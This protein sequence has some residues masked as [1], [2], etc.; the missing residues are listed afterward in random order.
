[1]RILFLISIRSKKG[2]LADQASNFPAELTTLSLGDLLGLEI[3]HGLNFNSHA[4]EPEIEFV[5]LADALPEHFR[6]QIITN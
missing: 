2:C 3:T 1:M 5:C 6:P 4:P